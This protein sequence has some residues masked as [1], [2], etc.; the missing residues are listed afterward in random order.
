MVAGGN[1][2][3]ECTT[4]AS[5]TPSLRAGTIKG[6]SVTSKDRDPNLPDVP[7]T[8][9]SGYPNVNIMQSYVISGPPK[10]PAFIIAKLNKAMEEIFR[11]PEAIAKFRSIGIEISYHNSEA[12]RKFIIKESDDLSKLWSSVQ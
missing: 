10:L 6:L 12:A 4:V 1:A 2:V 3:L 11:D 9:E 5:A 8:A 7:T